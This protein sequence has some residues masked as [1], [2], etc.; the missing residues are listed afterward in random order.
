MAATN[1]D[2]ATL[3]SLHNR[4]VRLLR[5]GRPL[6]RDHRVPRRDL[7]ARLQNLGPLTPDAIADGLEK[8]AI[9]AFTVRERLRRAATE[10]VIT[11]EPN[12]PWVLTAAEYAKVFLIED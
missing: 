8:G 1:L 6:P 11:H 10:G 2:T 9:S 12:Q 5:Q 4:T 3:T 7:L